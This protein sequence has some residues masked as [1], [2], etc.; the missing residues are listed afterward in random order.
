NAVVAVHCTH[1]V[2]RTGF[3]IASYLV[4]RHRFSVREA[5]QHFTGARFPGMWRQELVD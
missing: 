3:L 1:G 5:L 4:R 2:N